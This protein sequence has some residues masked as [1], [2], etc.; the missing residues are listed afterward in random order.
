M[1]CNALRKRPPL[2]DEK[3]GDGGARILLRGERKQFHESPAGIDKSL[4]IFLASWANLIRLMGPDVARG[5]VEK[6]S[7]DVKADN[8]PSRQLVLPAQANQ[9]RKLGN[10]AWQVVRNQG[11]EDAIHSIV[12]Q[13]AACVM[14]L[15]G[16]EG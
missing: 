10:E 8:H 7:L 4:S 13:S 14:E 9:V 3:L 12:R 16:I 1:D 11:C 6:R 5:R 15:F 2:L